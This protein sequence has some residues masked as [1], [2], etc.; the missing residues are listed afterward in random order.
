MALKAA[1]IHFLSYVRC[2]WAMLTL[3]CQELE[4]LVGCFL[5]MQYLFFNCEWHILMQ[6]IDERQKHLVL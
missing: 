5:L 1:N 6:N 2:K 4:F 3:L